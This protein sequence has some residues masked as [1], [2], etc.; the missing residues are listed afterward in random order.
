[1]VDEARKSQPAD[2]AFWSWLGF[3]VQFLAL[4][5]CVV[6]GAFAASGAEGPGDYTAGL[7]LMISA[8]VLAFLRLKQTFD[9]H[10]G[11]LANVLLVDNY[12]GLAVVVPLFVIVG[13]A[14][15]FIARDWPTGALHN[16]GIALFLFSGL[17]VYLDIKQVFDRMN[18]R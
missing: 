7:I 10:P 3:W 15:L 16:G 6:L 2:T 11:G 8:L 1:M 14:G 9:Q 12:A 4:G 13:L 18:P 5:L 17:I